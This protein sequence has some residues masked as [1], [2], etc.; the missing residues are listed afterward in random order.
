MNKDCKVMNF[1][2]KLSFSRDY[3]SYLLNIGQFFIF[4]RAKTDKPRP[5]DT[6]NIKKL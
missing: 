2:V 6:I 1:P 5:D 3:D 4:L